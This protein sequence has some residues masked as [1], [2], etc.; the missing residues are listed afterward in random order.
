MIGVNGSKPFI[1]SRESKLMTLQSE[2][3][4]TDNILAMNRWRDYEEK[5]YFEQYKKS[6]M[7]QI[8]EMELLGSD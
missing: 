8:I 1:T 2:L 4:L 3:D 5:K 6:I 7:N